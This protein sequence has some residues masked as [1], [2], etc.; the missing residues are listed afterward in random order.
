MPRSARGQERVLAGAADVGAWLFRCNPRDYWD[1]IGAL[2]DGKI[3]NNW[4]AFPSYRLGLIIAGQPVVLWVTGRSGRKPEP[5]IWMAG[6]TTG[7]IIDNGQGDE[8]WLDEAEQRK[9]RPYVELSM[10]QLDPVLLRE[11]VA[12]DVRTARMEILRNP[13]MGNPSYLTHDEKAAVEEM[14]GS[15]PAPR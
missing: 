9:P 1:I 15:W 5:G 13:Q 10:T 14:I 6:F 2:A 12:A 8:Y 7:E 4:R 3:V 11:R